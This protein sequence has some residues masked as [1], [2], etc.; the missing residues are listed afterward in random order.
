MKALI[1][2]GG[3]GKRISP[4]TKKVPKP[5]LPINRRP[6]LEHIIEWLKRQHI[7][8]IILCTYYLSDVIMQHFKNGSQFDVRIQYSV[9]EEPLGTAGAI[10]RA[11]KYLDDTFLALNGDTCWEMDLGRFLEFHRRKQAA[12]SIALAKLNN[13][14]RYGI[15]EISNEGRIVSFK[16]KK[17]IPGEAYVSAGIYVLEPR[18]LSYILPGVFSSIEKEVF[19]EMLASD[20]PLF[21]YK[22]VKRFVDIGKLED[23]HR[24]K[25]EALT[26]FNSLKV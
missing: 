7:R 9:E 4:L 14:K 25:R 19:P 11:Q 18:V 5:M 22:G 15:I 10:H 24:L 16:E 17:S 26:I 3:F 21:A 2:A 6:F 8:D 13:P 1:L 20:E 12:G 23:Y